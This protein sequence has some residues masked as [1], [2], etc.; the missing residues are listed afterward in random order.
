MPA[1][2]GSAAPVHEDIRD[3]R[4]ERHDHPCGPGGE[5]EYGTAAAAGAAPGQHAAKSLQDRADDEA[6]G[7]RIFAMEISPAYVDVA[8]DRWQPA[9]GRNA[10]LKGDGHPFAAVRQ[11]RLGADAEAA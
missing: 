2:R 1:P 9:T 10:I 7:R 3:A 4:A 6:N 8:I 11:E 5:R